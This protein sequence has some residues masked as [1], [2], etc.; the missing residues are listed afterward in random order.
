MSR[1]TTVG[2]PNLPVTPA[3]LPR[4]RLSLTGRLTGASSNSKGEMKHY[5]H[6]KYHLSKTSNKGN[7]TLWL[8]ISLG[9]SSE[10]RK[11]KV[12]SH[13]SPK[14]KILLLLHRYN[15][16]KY[17]FQWLT[18]RMTCKA[19]WQHFTTSYKPMLV[20]KRRGCREWFSS[21]IPRRENIS[22]WPQQQ[23]ITQKPA[24]EE[25]LKP[26]L[27]CN[28]YSCDS[29]KPLGSTLPWKLQIPGIS[30]P[31]TAPKGSAWCYFPCC[32]TLF[33]ALRYISMSF[34]NKEL[35]TRPN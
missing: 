28:I 1:Y 22:R 9:S 8:H 30:A 25:S 34:R 27:C 5:N 19:N 32:G 6:H 12:L 14:I 16:N 2:Q 18:R 29:H 24:G 11:V 17:F 4:N 10:E 3:L 20:F 13:S 31:R 23:P 15:F 35:T 26:R 7:K 21:K 33:Q